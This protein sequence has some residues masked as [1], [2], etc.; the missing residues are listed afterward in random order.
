MDLYA[1]F[2]P[3]IGE[4]FPLGLVARILMGCVS[5]LCA[6]FCQNNS[7]IKKKNLMKRYWHRFITIGFLDSSMIKSFEK[8]AS[9]VCQ[10]SKSAAQQI[11]PGCTPRLLSLLLFFLLVHYFCSGNI[12]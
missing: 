9:A 3:L 7:A 6:I 10:F 8:S 12:K 1:S 4:T 2:L 11:P 5:G